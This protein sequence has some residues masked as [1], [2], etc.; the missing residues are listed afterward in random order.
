MQMLNLVLPGMYTPGQKDPATTLVAHRMIQPSLSIALLKIVNGDSS[1][2]NNENKKTTVFVEDEG[3][4]I[5]LV[6]LP[7]AMRNSNGGLRGNCSY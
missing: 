1:N 6:S 3:S 5:G 4:R 2:N 7:L